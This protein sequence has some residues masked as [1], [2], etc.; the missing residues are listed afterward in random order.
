MQIRPKALQGLQPFRSSFNNRIFS[1]E[2]LA[3]FSFYQNAHHLAH[4]P[5]RRAKHL[6]AFCTRNKQGNTAVSNYANAL[7]KAIEGF[8]FKAGEIDLL[9][10]LGGI[11]QEIDSFS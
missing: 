1:L 10:L 4:A 8:Q 11:R 7:G 9:E 2:D 3:A 5:T 6:Q